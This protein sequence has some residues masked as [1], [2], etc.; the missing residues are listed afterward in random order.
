MHVL[1]FKKFTLN[2]WFDMLK[3]FKLLLTKVVRYQIKD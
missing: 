1:L 2:F 3:K